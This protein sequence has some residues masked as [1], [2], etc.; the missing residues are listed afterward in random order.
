[1]FTNRLAFGGACDFLSTSL[2][3]KSGTCGQKVPMF[4]AKSSTYACSKR[5]KNL[6]HENHKLLIINEKTGKTM[7]HMKSR[8]YDPPWYIVDSKGNFFRV[9]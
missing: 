6:E 7:F 1:M 8:T 5:E 4:H 9:C 2:F 3:F